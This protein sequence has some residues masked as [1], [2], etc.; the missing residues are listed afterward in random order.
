MVRTPDVVFGDTCFKQCLAD[1]RVFRVIEEGRMA[2][3]V[4]VHV[5]D[6]LFAVGL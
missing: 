6:I 3:T 1:V 2:M 4:V 5:D